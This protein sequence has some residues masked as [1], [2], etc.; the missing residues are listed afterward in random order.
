MIDSSAT[1]ATL[2]KLPFLKQYP[3]KQGHLPPFIVKDERLEVEELTGS[4]VD[5]LGAESRAGLQQG[6]ADDMPY[7]PGRQGALRVIRT[8]RTWHRAKTDVVLRRQSD[9]IYVAFDVAAESPLLYLK[10]AVYGALFLGGWFLGLWLYFHLVNPDGLIVQFAQKYG[11]GATREVVEMLK[12]GWCFEQA[13]GAFTQCASGVGWF[14]LFQ[15]DP[16]LFI[17]YLLWPIGIIAG[18]SGWALKQMPASLVD[19]PCQYLDWP[20]PQEF[21]SF[22]THHAAWMQSVLSGVLFDR[23]GIEEQHIQRI[24][25]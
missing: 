6:W 16:P 14:D 18:L 11:G 20:T 15:R 5:R 3:L 10:T 22:A 23:Y 8:D 24:Y 21:E 7:V 19:R 12:G 4:L 9:G 2:P 25:Q 1:L 13:T 17:S